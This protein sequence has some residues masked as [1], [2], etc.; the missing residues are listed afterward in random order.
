MAERDHRPKFHFAPQR[1]WMNDPNG[2]FFHKGIYHLYFQYYPKDIV[3]G[4]MHWG[5]ATSKDLVSWTEHAVALSPD[6][7]GYIFSGCAVVD[8][9]NTSGFGTDENTAIIAIFTYHDPIAE[10]QGNLKHQSQALAYSLDGGFTFTKYANNPI[11]NNPGFKDF[12]DPKIVRDILRSQ[13]V[14][15]LSTY[16]ETLF[17]TSENL[18]DWEYQSSFG[19]D[20]GAHGGVWECPDLFP[21]NVETDSEAQKETKWVLLQ[22]LNPGGPNGGSATQYFIGDFDGKTY[23]LD[24]NFSKSLV[25]NCANWLDHGKDNYAAVSWSNIP[26]TDGRRLIIGW[27]SNWDYGNETPATKYRGRMTIPRALKL[28]KIK[29]EYLLKTEPIDEINSFTDRTKTFK[30]LTFEDKHEIVI[31]PNTLNTA[32]LELEF[33]KLHASN[34]KIRLSNSNGEQ[35]EFGVDTRKSQYY[36]DRTASG[37]VSFSD[38]FANTISTANLN[39]QLENIN[40]KALLDLGS[41]EIFFNQGLIVMTETF[42]NTEPFTKITI[43]NSSGKLTEIKN[44]I[45]KSFN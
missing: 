1:G 16:G 40:I 23:H 15:V 27:M 31:D 38:S 36:V 20:I 4:P 44:L 22:S 5:H 35:L 28:Q 7:K 26:D 21:I 19:K 37:L 25:E 39:T 9:E 13:W 45:I 12:R 14:M 30:D 18:I 3:W 8:V 43:C 17:Y 42:Y 10:V 33:S 24:E 41:I 34:Y 29:G 11:I 2:M 32:L 6:E